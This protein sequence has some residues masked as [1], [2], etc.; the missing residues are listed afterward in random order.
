MILDFRDAWSIHPGIERM[1]VIARVAERYFFPFVEKACMRQSDLLLFATPLLCAQYIEKYPAIKSKSVVLPNGFDEAAFS[2]S[3]TNSGGDDHRFFKMLFGG[4]CDRMKNPQ[5]LLRAISQLRHLP[6]RLTI[7]GSE[8]SRWRREIARHGL[9][10][11]CTIAGRKPYDEYIR[12]LCRADLY[13]IIVDNEYHAAISTR[14]YDCL[15]AGGTILLMSAPG[16]NRRM[17]EK[18]SPHSF[19][20]DLHDHDAIASAIMQAFDRWKNGKNIR[21]THPEI[22]KYDRKAIAEK[23]SSIIRA[24]SANERLPASTTW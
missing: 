10:D 24:I 2:P 16:E 20:V 6:L 18:Y 9:Q 4:S 12:E 8:E 13:L 3:Q 17:V 22:A 23:L 21:Q 15:R 1:S 7:M 14:T 19:C 5:E 11:M